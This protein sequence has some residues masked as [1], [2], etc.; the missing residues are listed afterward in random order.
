MHQL[1]T[2]LTCDKPGILSVDALASGIVEPFEANIQMCMQWA[3]ANGSL[4]MSSACQQATC[5][6]L[7]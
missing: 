2:K 3:L 7:L 4:I 6:W 5:N 1:A